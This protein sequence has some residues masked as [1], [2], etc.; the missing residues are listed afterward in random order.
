MRG[1]QESQ[2]RGEGAE[3]KENGR[4]EERNQK[5]GERWGESTRPKEKRAKGTRRGGR[6]RGKEK[7][8][9]ANRNGEGQRRKR[10]VGEVRRGV[11]EAWK[12]VGERR[13]RAKGS[14]VKQRLTRGCHMTFFGTFC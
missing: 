13:E 5:Q 12:I 14:K 1:S 11:K 7:R 9:G 8:K 4:G 2:K 3:E 10:G 6:G